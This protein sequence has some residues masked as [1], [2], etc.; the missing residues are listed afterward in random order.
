[1][2]EE[3]LGDKPILHILLDSNHQ[4]SMVH[5]YDLHSTVVAALFE[6]QMEHKS[7]Q[8]LEGVEEEN[9]NDA[10]VGDR[11]GETLPCGIR[12]LKEVDASAEKKEEAVLAPGI[13]F[14]RLH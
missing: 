5:P 11:V 9:Y 6:F 7:R 10:L 2:E 14:D 4:Q 13:A 8:F 3:V 1:V 12:R